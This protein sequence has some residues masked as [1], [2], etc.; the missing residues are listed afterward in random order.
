MHDENIGFYK[1]RMSAFHDIVSLIS[2]F[3]FGIIFT[4]NEEKV[5]IFLDKV[6]M[7]FAIIS[8]VIAVFGALIFWIYFSVSGNVHI[9]NEKKE[10]KKIEIRGIVT[11][12][13]IHSS[14]SEKPTIEI[15]ISCFGNTVRINEWG[16][17]AT[18]ASIIIV[19]DSVSK[20]PSE[21]EI[22]VFRENKFLMKCFPYND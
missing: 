15:E 18:F 19:G 8:L 22:D 21:Y 6:L 2:I 5:F 16:Q 10:W 7:K 4:M 12:K 13:D 20:D 3:V 17:D 14:A 1:K 11:K 9:D